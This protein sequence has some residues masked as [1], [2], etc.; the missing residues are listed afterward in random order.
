MLLESTPLSAAAIRDL[1]AHLLGELIRPAHDDYAA[2]RQVWNRTI[3]RYPALIVRAADAA[4]V[5][6]AVSFARGTTCRWRCAAAATAWPAT[7]PSTAA[8]CSTWGVC[9]G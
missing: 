9:R 2:A 3:D 7:A 4:D 5:I 1:E 8:W 6:R